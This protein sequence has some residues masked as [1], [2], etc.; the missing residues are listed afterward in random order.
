MYSILYPLC[1]IVNY[2]KI[3]INKDISIR[4]RIEILS[5]Y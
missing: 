5:M 2:N 1:L 4:P 3:K